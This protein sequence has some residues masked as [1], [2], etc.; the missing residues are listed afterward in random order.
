MIWPLLLNTSAANEPSR[1]NLTNAVVYEVNFRAFS[2]EGGFEGVT[3]RLDQIRSVGTTVLWLMPI[4]PVG[5]VRSAGGLGSP[6]AVQNYDEVNPEFGTRVQFQ[7]LV[8]EAHRRKMRVVLDW[9]GNHTAWD[10]PWITQ[11][12]EWY[13]RNASGEIQIP[14]GTNWK[15]VADLDFSNQDM[16][17]AMLKSMLRWVQEE[18]IDGFRCDYADGVP[19]DFWTSTVRALRK[20][21]RRPLFMLGEGSRPDL[22]TSGFDLTYGWPEYGLIQDIFRGKRPAQALE[23]AVLKQPATCLRFITNHDESAWNAP[24]TQVFGGA[25]AAFG[26]FAVSAFSP[27]VPLINNGQEIAWPKGIPIFDRSMI[28][29]TTGATD[30]G[31]YQQL[32]RFR[33]KSK[34]AQRGAFESLSSDRVVAFTKTLG[35]EQ[36]LLIVNA[37]SAPQSLALSTEYSTTW[38]SAFSSKPFTLGTALSLNPH[39]TVLLRRTLIK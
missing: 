6:Y 23:S 12:P 14:A 15:D 27:G 17:A 16:R 9:V 35:K 22:L 32:M 18:K 39:E 7:K 24:V 11:H 37:S 28:D 3:E 30:L 1:M 36:V 2:K 26:A 33:A 8:R 19:S 4:Y 29:W 13:T 5:K 31:R 38:T 10:H 21:V 34:A 20:S 25:D